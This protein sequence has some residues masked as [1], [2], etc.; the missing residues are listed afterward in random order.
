MLRLC[1]SWRASP[2]TLMPQR[3]L[4]F[5]AILAA[6]LLALHA[7]KTTANLPPANITIISN[8]CGIGIPDVA[9]LPF[10]AT[11]VIENERTL[12]DGSVLT[13]RT[14]NLIARDSA[15]RTRTE[16]RRLMPES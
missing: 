13:Q 2:Q 7:Q 8:A 12:R 11:V 3:S 6:S 16:M 9:G 5:A 1:Y 14:I 4:V 15:G 10:S